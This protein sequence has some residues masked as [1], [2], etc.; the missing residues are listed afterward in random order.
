M[1]I[2]P[3]V[4]AAVKKIEDYVTQSTG[5][6]PTPEELADAMTRYFV[7]KEIL[8]FIQMSRGGDSL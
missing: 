5:Q 2:S 4:A 6:K 8:A 1:S 3:E 7:L